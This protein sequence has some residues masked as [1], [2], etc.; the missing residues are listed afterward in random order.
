[1]RQRKEKNSNSMLSH[2]DYLSRHRIR[3]AERG[4]EI[5]EGG[6]KKLLAK[7][8][9]TDEL[10]SWEY[11]SPNSKEDLEGKDFRV[12]MM[13]DGKTVTILF[14]VTISLESHQKHQARYPD[15]PSILIPINMT[16]ERIWYRICRLC[17]EQT[18]AS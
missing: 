9:K 14:G 3:Q 16:E 18:N 11:F 15:V 6:A 2:R 10:I 7:K 13:V 17:R 1:M 8:Q 12:T 4:R 5:I